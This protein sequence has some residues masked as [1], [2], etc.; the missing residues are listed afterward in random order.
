VVP[1]DPA[2]GPE[3]DFGDLRKRINSLPLTVAERA[4]YED[5]AASSQTEELTNFREAII[6]RVVRIHATVRPGCGPNTM[7][8][9]PSTE[10]AGTEDA[11]LVLD[12]AAA[13][14]EEHWRQFVVALSK[15]PLDPP[16]APR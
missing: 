14:V 15:W 1:Q 8:I 16:T 2:S 7:T 10:A 4:W 11:G 9:S 13:F 3:W 6:H 5:L 12:R